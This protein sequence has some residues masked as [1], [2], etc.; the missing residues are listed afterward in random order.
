MAAERKSKAPYRWQAFTH[1]AHLSALAAT[2]VAG[3]VI[4]P[5]L[6]LLAVPL[7]M[8]ALWVIP[9]LPVFKARVDRAHTLRELARERAYYLDQLWGLAR[10][11]K[12]LG[13]RMADWFFDVEEDLDSRVISRD[14][15]F[16][17]YQELRE[18]V[19]KLI[20]LEKVRGV[21]IV[22]H[23]IQRFEQVVNG[24]LR[25]LIARQSLR[26]ALRGIEPAA[27]EHEL[28]DIDRQLVD[29]DADLR[30]VLLERRRL[31]QAQLERLPKLRAMHELFKTRADAI[32]YQMRNVYGQVLADPGVN[33]NAFLEDLA[34]KHELLADPLGDLEADQSVRELLREVQ[35]DL[36]PKAAPKGAKAAKAARGVSQ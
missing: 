4:D 16:E 1:W 7:E 10:S 19:A 25:Y 20:E 18:I 13:R 34:E 35:A 27:L 2:G 12:S 22:S 30:A 9:D 8:G 36:D 29:A 3:A 24:Y 11:R 32:V 23:E 21:P 17:R 5:S 15:S 28:A 14:S 33:V 6:W 26:D 31:R